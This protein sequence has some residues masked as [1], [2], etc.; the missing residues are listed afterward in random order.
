MLC[1]V[2]ASAAPLLCRAAPVVVG[3]AWWASQ[4]RSQQ[5]SPWP[6]SRHYS[7]AELQV[8]TGGALSL[9]YSHLHLRFN[10]GSCVQQPHLTLEQIAVQCVFVRVSA[11][12]LA[13]WLI[14]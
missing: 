11:V 8:R 1:A 14:A 6:G 7:T 13:V 10:T 3:S 4:A 12:T 9:L 5:L 2:S